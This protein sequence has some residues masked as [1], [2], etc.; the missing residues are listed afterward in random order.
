MTAPPRPPAHAAAPAPDGAAGGA[1]PDAPGGSA[2]VPLTSLPLVHRGKVRDVFEI[3]A[4]HWLIVATDRL[5]A[6]DVVLPT[7]VPGKGRLLTGIARFWFARYRAM[8][9]NHLAPIPLEEV[10]PDPAERALVEGRSMVVRRLEPVPF[11]A[12]VRGHLAGSGW[13]DYLATGAVCGHALPAG[14]E[15][16]S[17]LERPIFT[18]ATKAA[19]GEHDENVD[20]EAMVAAVGR[21][22]AEDV[23]RVSIAIYRDAARHAEARG[24][25]VADTKLEFGHDAAGNLALMDEVLTPDSSRF[26]EA[27]TWRPG[28]SPASFD[29]QYVRDWLETLDWDKR[30]PGPEVPEAVVAGTLAR[31]EEARRRL[32]D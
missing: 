29:K 30:A 2:D 20:F 23:R 11:E 9:P 22:T 3:D 17:R 7:R 8:L 18:P 13:R 28:T 10:L 15:Q 19:P 6:F 12:V 32:V 31:Y 4:V 27:S 16:A 1:T 25:V 14:L 26:W 24:I 5:S 21:E